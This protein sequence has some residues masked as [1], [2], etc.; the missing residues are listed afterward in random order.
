MFVLFAKQND[1]SFFNDCK[2]SK[3]FLSV[4]GAL[5]S[6]ERLSDEAGHEELFAHQAA[7]NWTPKTYFHIQ[8]L[9]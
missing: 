3:S 1:K 2:Q 7:D 8:R 5:D 6:M 9:L 4:R